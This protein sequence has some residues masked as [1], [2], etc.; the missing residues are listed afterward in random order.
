[1]KKVNLLII[2][3]LLISSMLVAA[4]PARLVRLDVINQTGGNVYIKLNGA[5]TGAFY[6]LTVPPGGK[7]FT[8]LPDIYS[9]TT[10]ACGYEEKGRLVMTSNVRLNFVP[11][12]VVPTR[13]VV[14]GVGNDL[15]LM[16][17]WA[18]PIPCIRAVNPGE[19]TMEKV[20]WFQYWRSTVVNAW[21]GFWGVKSS[22]KFVPLGCYWRY[23]Y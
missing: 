22:W 3:V 6:Y 19:P 13:I 21:C 20:V 12:G 17:P 7:S 15:C 1:M 2:A 11:C 5:A 10:W 18:P 23:R 14:L 16:V 9:R 4:D 8:L